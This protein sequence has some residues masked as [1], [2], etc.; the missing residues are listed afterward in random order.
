M[1]HTQK[2]STT[3]AVPRPPCKVL[4]SEKFVRL[5]NNQPVPRIQDLMNRLGV[6][7]RSGLLSLTCAK[8][9]TTLR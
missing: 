9:T 4:L 8:A 2:Y 1:G 3:E 7:R 6:E 5:Q